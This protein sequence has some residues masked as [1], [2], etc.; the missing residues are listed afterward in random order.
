[1]ST[2]PIKRADISEQCIGD[3]LYLYGPDG[4]QLL[5][6]NETGMLIWSLC[7]G[8][9][10]LQEIQEIIE[11]ISWDRPADAIRRDIADF[12]NDLRR[13]RLIEFRKTPT[14]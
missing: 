3:E 11:E 1:M 9:H 7:D 8:E 10:A 4:N 14:D 13:M 12:L 6:L 5:V 2:Y